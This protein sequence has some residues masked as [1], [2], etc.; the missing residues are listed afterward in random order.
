MRQ[1]GGFTMVEMLVVIAI[2]SILA[3]LLLP[4]LIGSKK[5]AKR[6]VCESQLQQIGIAFQSFAHDHN[7]KFPMQV[8]TNDGGSLEFVQNSY[9]INGPFYFGYQNFQTLA[10]FLQNPDVLVCPA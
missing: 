10:G 6:I 8:S 4:G 3:A 2:I 7:S 9:V 1:T 5:R